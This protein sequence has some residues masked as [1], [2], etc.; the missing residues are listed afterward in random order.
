MKKSAFLLLD[1]FFFVTVSSVFAKGEPAWFLDKNKAYPKNQ[2]LCETG[3]GITEDDAKAAALTALVNYI[4][5]DVQALTESESRMTNSDGTVT[6]NQEMNRTVKVSSN[7]K[8]SGVEYSQLYFDKKKK[9]YYAA[10]F[11]EREKLYKQ[12]AAT[13]TKL[14]KQIDSKINQAQEEL[15]EKNFLEAYLLYLQAQSNSDAY[16]AAYYINISID[17]QRAEEEFS[18]F[19]DTVFLLSSEMEKAFQKALV[20]VEIEG[21]YKN[22]ITNTITALLKKNG[23]TVSKDK[24]KAGYVM[25]GEVEKHLA[26]GGEEVYEA[27]PEI[28]LNLKHG[29]EILFSYNVTSEPGEKKIFSYDLNKIEKISADRCVEKINDGFEE[30]IIS[31]LGDEK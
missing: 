30:K 7:I 8:I 24:E 14:Q 22:I 9:L 25:Y 2:F 1:I 3:S 18:E 21:D 26:G 15:K 20:Y 6:R 23:F 10:C 11:I 4:Q 27:L 19:T 13:L 5:S 17:S 12:N 29:E 31:F 16:L 28:S